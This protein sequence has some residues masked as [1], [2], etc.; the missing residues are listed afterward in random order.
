MCLHT[1]AQLHMRPVVV[2][3]DSLQQLHGPVQVHEQKE[4]KHKEGLWA[5]PSN[6]NPLEKQVTTLCYLCIYTSH[7]NPCACLETQAAL[8]GTYIRSELRPLLARQAAPSVVFRAYASRHIVSDITPL[9][10]CDSLVQCIDTD[11]ISR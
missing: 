2:L 4:K 5:E 8:H 10:T 3:T 1:N 6:K 7:A 11:F 9:L